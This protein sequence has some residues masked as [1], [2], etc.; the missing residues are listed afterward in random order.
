MDP[1]TV[2]W[3]HHLWTWAQAAQPALADLCAVQAKPEAVDT[4]LVLDI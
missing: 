3:K 2:V 4:D 1:L